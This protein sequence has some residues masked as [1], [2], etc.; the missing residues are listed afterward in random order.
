MT[1]QQPEGQ[2]ASGS[3]EEL[4][5]DIERTRQELGETVEALAAKADVKGQ[6]RQKASQIK[7]QAA[8]ARVHCLTADEFFAEES[9]ANL[10]V[11]ALGICPG[12]P[13]GVIGQSY[14]GK[15]IVTL[16][17]GVSVAVGVIFGLYPA[18]KAARIDPI[19]ALRY[20]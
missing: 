16:S 10:I 17:F 14:A 18:M 15:T 2:S 5:E 20:E 4:R 9:E 11:P 8:D 6:A 13:T 7:E 3:P 12:P 1:T 19:E